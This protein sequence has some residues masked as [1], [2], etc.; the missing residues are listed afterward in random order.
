MMPSSR[1]AISGRAVPSRA[2]RISRAPAAALLGLAIGLL[3]LAGCA[4]FPLAPGAQPAPP[5]DAAEVRRNQE[6]LLAA[7]LARIEPS[8]PTVAETYFVG[9]APYAEEVFRREVEHVETLFRE[10]L[11]AEGRTVLLVNSARTVHAAPLANARNLH[12][13]L[14]GIAAKMDAEDTLFLHIASH[15]SKEHAIAAAFDPLPPQS[16]DLL[17][18]RDIGAEELGR[19][20]AGAGLPWRVIVVSACYSGGFIKALKSPRALVMSAARA[21]R[22]S[23][24]CDAGREYTYF[25]EAFYRDSLRD[26]DYAAAFRRAAKRVTERERAE[27]HTPSEPQI[28]IGGEF[29]KRAAP[30]DERENGSQAREMQP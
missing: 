15:G 20:V 4:G 12:A 3:G 17:Q 5:F 11:G 14:A 9:F 27:G 25:G 10:T 29:A 30:D 8:Q 18:L 22:P 6:A 16:L 13:V 28:W 26:H 23:F 1:S 24:G 19:I 2:R 21:D 7:A